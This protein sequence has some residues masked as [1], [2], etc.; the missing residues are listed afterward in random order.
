MR[1]AVGPELARRPGSVHLGHSDFCLR[2]LG[3]VDGLYV[4]E[5]DGEVKLLLE[6][7]AEAGNQ[8]TQADAT[9]VQ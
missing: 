2:G 9:R 8:V 3:G 6:S 5:L 4:A 1:P 7:L